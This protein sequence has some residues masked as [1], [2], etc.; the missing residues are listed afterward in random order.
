M[1]NNV[2]PLVFQVLAGLWGNRPVQLNPKPKKGRLTFKNVVFMQSLFFRTYLLPAQGACVFTFNWTS[3]RW[4]DWFRRVQNQNST[5]YWKLMNYV[6]NR[7]SFLAYGHG[8]TKTWSGVFLEPAVAVT[9]ST[10]M[11]STITVEIPAIRYW[12]IDSPSSWLG[13]CYTR[14]NPKQRHSTAKQQLQ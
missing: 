13:S 3:F 1:E 11:V 10:I 12:F 8:H 6:F 5:N 2:S 14:R 7:W 9:V 4:K